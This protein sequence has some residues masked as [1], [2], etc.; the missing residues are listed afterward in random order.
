MIKNRKVAT[1]LIIIFIPVFVLLIVQL[2]YN[3]VRQNEIF[4]QTEAIFNDY[5][6]QSDSLLLNADRDF[7]QAALAEARIYYQQGLSPEETTALIQDFQENVSQTT[8]RFYQAIEIAKNDPELY[9]SYSLK[10]LFIA[11]NGAN[12]DDPDGF[13][14]NDMTLQQIEATFN[15]DFNI[16]INLYDLET[17]QGDWEK[18]QEA[19]GQTREHLNT[20]TDLLA[21]Y[22]TYESD[23]LQKEIAA[24]AA[25]VTSITVVIIILSLLIALVVAAYLRNNIVRLT[26]DMG[27]LADNDL[28]FTPSS[29]NSQDELGN[30]SEAMNT[31]YASLKNMILNMR[32]SSDELTNSSQ[33]MNRATTEIN[34]SMT[35]IQR[36]MEDIA[37]GAMTQAED[38]ESFSRDMGNLDVVMRK[39]LQTSVELTDESQKIKQATD[40]GMK[41]IEVL[42]EVTKQNNV[43]FQNIF[44]V[45]NNISASTEQIGQASQLISDI[46]D[47]TNL[48]SLNASIEAARAGESGRGFAVVAE[49][50]RKL[51]EQ[52]A[53]SVTSID[54][55]LMELQ[56]NAK[57]AHEQSILV[58]DGV[59]RQ[60]ASVNTTQEQYMEI[61]HSIKNV[62]H[63]IQSLNEVNR[64]LET[65][66]GS[67]SDLMGNLSAVSEENS[68][69][70]E[71]FASTIETIAGNMT[72]IK[73]TSDTVDYS[74]SGLDEIIKK[75]KCEE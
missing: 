12:A 30:L 25:V 17:G 61:V 6:Y 46:A 27:R 58:K 51:A 62:N 11:V 43:S 3:N 37:E 2:V 47:Q 70:L 45:I 10:S 15:K 71:E 36:A 74:S 69:T 19:F 66:F 22:S 52:S 16:W 42:M 68:A 4:D 8:D 21:L 50:I 38:T 7:Y 64:E 5:L 13:L 53:E 32:T 56:N 14:N 1:K 44:E 28:T 35:E 48:L 49:E 23:L 59:E 33:I 24:S 65:N 73:K 60:N 72:E 57:L 26:K 63:G 20:V 55:V 75:F 67:M 54:A 41:G 18:R 31:M 29:L 9:T 40:S 39:S 34:S